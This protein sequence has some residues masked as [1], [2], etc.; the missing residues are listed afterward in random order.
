MK[1]LLLLCPLCCLSLL[2]VAQDIIVT[3]DA[4]KINAKILEVSKSEIKYKEIDNLEGPTFILDTSDI[5]IIIYANGKVVLYNKATDD[6]EA[7]VC[8]KA[9]KSDALFTISETQAT[10]GQ[11]ITQNTEGNQWGLQGR[12]LIGKLA[13]PEYQ[14]LQ[15]GSVIV[16]IV[17]SAAGNVISAKHAG[18]T[19]T[20]K[21]TIQCAT[22]AAR[23]A[24]FSKG[25]SNQTGTITYNFKIK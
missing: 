8:E 6:T 23:K 16:E 25:G 17:V 9:E 1:K 15:E 14:G 10:Q 4:K 13:T 21:Q 3:A 24:K 2:A 7:K 19:I 12:S 11:P 5:N 20:D 18:G 22:E